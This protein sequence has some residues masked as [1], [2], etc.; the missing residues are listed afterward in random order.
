MIDAAVR[1]GRDGTDFRS[2]LLALVSTSAPAPAPPRDD[3]EEG[4]WRR[5]A[6]GAWSVVDRFDHDGRRYV[7][8][9]RNLA[10]APRRGL[11]V[12]ERQVLALAVRGHANKYIAYELGLATSTVAMYLAAAMRKLG[13]STRLELL[14]LLSRGL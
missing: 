6:S 1:A 3:D 5:I 2:A 9:R 14:A 10:S 11:S 7:I 4:V 13:L 8:A 12:R